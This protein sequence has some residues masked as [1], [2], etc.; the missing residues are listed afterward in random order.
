M[1]AS[2]VGHTPPNYALHRTRSRSVL[3]RESVQSDVRLRAGERRGRWAANE[4]TMSLDLLAFVD[5]LPDRASWQAAIDQAGVDLKL[6]PTLEVDRDE[7]FSPC[8]IN[9]RS[10]G[11]ELSTEPA[12]E[13]LR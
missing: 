5:Q 1:K 9:G 11:F 4:D 13:V 7:G 2:T 12:T 10:S 8:E 6:D 3:R